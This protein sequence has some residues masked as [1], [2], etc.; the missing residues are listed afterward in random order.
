MIFNKK[1]LFRHTILM[2]VCLLLGEAVVAGNP[3][4]EA[5]EIIDSLSQ[6][7]LTDQEEELRDIAS[8][9]NLAVEGLTEALE[10]PDHEVIEKAA[11]ILFLIGLET[12]LTEANSKQVAEALVDV[13]L[14]ASHSSSRAT[15]AQALQVLQPSDEDTVQ[16][17]IEAFTSDSDAIVRSKAALALTANSQRDDR[18]PAL[19]LSSIMSQDSV[20]VRSIAALS[21]SEFVLR[22]PE[23]IDQQI[24]ESLFTVI[25]DVNEEPTVIAHCVLAIGYAEV[26]DHSTIEVIAQ[27]LKRTETSNAYI[28]EQS[29][30]ALKQAANTL[31]NQSNGIEILEQNRQLVSEIQLLINSIPIKNNLEVDR[32]QEEIENLL[33]DTF[34]AKRQALFFQS[35]QRWVI[36]NRTVWILHPLVWMALVL[37][38]PMSRQVQAFFFWNKHVRAILGCWYVGP[39][40]AAIPPLR[41]RLF[42]PFKESL[43]AD[44]KL[45]LFEPNAYFRASEVCRKG[46]QQMQ[47]LLEVLPTIKGQ[48]VLEGE[49]GLGKTVFLRYLVQKTQR[50]TVYLPAQ[51]CENGVIEAIQAKLHGQAQDAEFL[52]HLIYSGALDICIDGLN[53]VRAEVRA[54]IT[55]F[56]ESYFKGNI[57]MTTQPLVWNPPA[58]AKTYVMQPLRTEQIQDFLLFRQRRLPESSVVQGQA[59]EQRC[60]TF[61]QKAFAPHQPQAELQSVRRI[62]S[63]PMDLSV[64]AQ[65]IS[66]DR[67]PDVHQLAMQ[68]Y[69]LMAADY[70]RS[71]NQQFPL[72]AFAEFVYEMRV[73]DVYGM[74]GEPFYQAL[75]IMEQPQ[76]RMVVSRQWQDQ[77]GEAHKEWS[78]RH[79]KIMEFFVVQTF[80][81]TTAEA[82]D[83]RQQHLGDPRF[84]GIYFLLARLLP[85][86]QALEL[87]EWLIHYAADTKDHTVCDDYV[88]ILRSRQESTQPPPARQLIED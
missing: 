37:A 82:I 58:T 74:A 27:L 9:G 19:L 88:Q 33:E 83:R 26:V 1:S 52:R 36:G 8:C 79:D 75:A 7:D 86:E 10:H 6:S 43:L 68:Q 31:F 17:L 18:I 29:S 85:V 20:E 46:T 62:L 56:V 73:G 11:Y 80:L 78:F 24:K 65:I 63:N 25:N 21:L 72:T 47:P 49:S 3:Q 76:H 4:C 40:I 64:A 45:E 59:Y 15:S 60:L 16:A 51:K 67:V 55:A 28:Y 54:N 30:I 5:G 2:I 48:M 70:E 81:G 35:A 42:A 53:E 12:S 34:P 22:H 14:N 57:V 69:S 13:L 44:A 23:L 66:H 41:Q 61:L 32:A 77:A 71:W 84:R 38:Y 87:R 39:M 50:I